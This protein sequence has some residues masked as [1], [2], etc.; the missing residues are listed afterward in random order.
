LPTTVLDATDRS[1]HDSDV[2]EPVKAI[3]SESGS[4]AETPP[5]Q[6]RSEASMIAFPSLPVDPSAKENSLPTQTKAG[7]SSNA[8]RTSTA[9]P[10]TPQPQAPPGGGVPKAKK[11][12][13]EEKEALMDKQ[14]ADIFGKFKAKLKVICLA[15]SYLALRR[16]ACACSPFILCHT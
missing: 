12:D 9:A 5:I 7:A 11:V 6:P 15:L 1:I 13:P 3:A 2:D 10:I 14:Y 4:D 8:A 16:L